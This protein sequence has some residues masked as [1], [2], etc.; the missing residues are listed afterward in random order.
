M[1]KFEN[2]DWHQDRRV[3]ELYE[4]K[5]PKPTIED[6]K[7]SRIPASPIVRGEGGGIRLFSESTQDLKYSR[8]YERESAVRLTLI[9]GTEAHVIEL[10][11]EEAMILKL[12]LE[13]IITDTVN[14]NVARKHRLEAE[15]QHKKDVQAWEDQRDR[16]LRKW[17]A[18]G[19]ITSAMID[20]MKVDDVPF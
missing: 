20:D 19:K 11:V 8:N 18:D 12:G 16:E 3:K 6:Y 14:L 1:V 17:L 2:L 5:H 7:E 15:N 4:E 9:K 10:T 13:A